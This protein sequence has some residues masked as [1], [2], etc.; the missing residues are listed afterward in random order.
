MENDCQIVEQNP[1]S[2]TSNSFVYVDSGKTFTDLRT[3]LRLHGRRGKLWY[4][5]ILNLM[6]HLRKPELAY[7][8]AIVLFLFAYYNY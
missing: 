5:L 6:S 8:Q 3:I 7:S 4:R 1:I 2:I